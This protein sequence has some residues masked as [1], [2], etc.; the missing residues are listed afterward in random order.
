M[1]GVRDSSAKTSR[2]AP[3]LP[4]HALSPEEAARHLGTDLQQGLHPSESA[5]RVRSVGSNALAETTGPSPMRILFAQ[6]QSPLVAVLLAAAVVSRLLGN[7]K[8][9]VA[10]GVVVAL[11]TALGFLQEYRAERAMFALRHL[12]VPK[13]R[14]RRAGRVTEVASSELVPGDLVLLEA[15]DRVPADARLVEAVGLRVDG[16]GKLSAGKRPLGDPGGLLVQQRGSRR[17]RADHR[18]SGGRGFGLRGVRLGFP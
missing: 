11:N 13:A 1:V 7:T 3:E 9:A 14:V 17:A 15:G 10:V 8:E 4:C 6:F 18:G 2:P 16:A 12:V 5:R